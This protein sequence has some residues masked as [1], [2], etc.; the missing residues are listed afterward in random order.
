MDIRQLAPTISVWVWVIL[1]L[2][3]FPDSKN[4]ISEILEL[5]TNEQVDLTC[6]LY[7]YK[8]HVIDCYDWDTCTVSLSLWVN[9]YTDM[10]IRL[11]WIDTP[12]LKGDEKEKWI[13]ARDFIRRKIVWKEV[14]IK[15]H[16]DKK[17]K[18]WRYLW[19][20]YLEWNNINNLMLD[21][22]YA[23]IYN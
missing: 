17:W 10:V 18:Y 13:I 9:I 19:E 20:I 23:V 16:Q 2:L 15:T 21:N 6:D 1:I 14:I 22:W 7:T 4:D 5:E 3:F 8:A 12:E 11:Y